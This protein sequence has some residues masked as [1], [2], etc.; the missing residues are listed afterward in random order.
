VEDKEYIAV[1]PDKGSL[2]TF[3]KI[4]EILMNI[5]GIK[6][7]IIKTSVDPEAAKVLQ[8]T[9]VKFYGMPS[10]AHKKDVVRK[11]ATLAGELLVVDELSLIKIGPMKFKLN[12]RDPYK[13]RGF[14][15]IFFNKIGHDVRFVSEKYKDK[16]SA[17]PSPPKNTYDFVGE[18][19]EEGEESDE[20]CDR[21]H[22]RDK[23]Q[24]SAHMDID[25]YR[26]SSESQC[27]QVGLGIGQK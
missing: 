18:D 27:R 9:W 13:L 16:S 7:K 11:I 25:C 12:C 8:A 17:P 10:I 2:E 24:K 5:H 6:V 15:R 3:S 26:G 23:F 4:S 19:E 1:F 22:R 20:D 14:V 21:K